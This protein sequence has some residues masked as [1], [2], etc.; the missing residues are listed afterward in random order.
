VRKEIPPRIKIQ[1]SPMF[2]AAA[3]FLSARDMT[4]RPWKRFLNQNG[5]VVNT[6]GL[7]NKA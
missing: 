2:D 4:Q 5:A 1:P 6:L 7:Q 3:Q